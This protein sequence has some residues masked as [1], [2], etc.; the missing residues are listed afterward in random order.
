MKYDI[1]D[2]QEVRKP[3]RNLPPYFLGY[4]KEEAEK[5]FKDFSNLLNRISYSFSVYTG[6][7][8][9]D[10]FGEALNGLAV[11]KRDCSPGLKHSFKAYA[12]VI[13]IDFLNEYARKYRATVVT[14]SYVRKANKY[15][16]EL[17]HCLSSTGFE[18]QVHDTS[19]IP[20][21]CIEFFDKLLRASKRAS[22]TVEE[23]VKRAEYLPTNTQYTENE[24]E[25]SNEEEVSAAL[26]VEKIKEYMTDEELII[27]DGIMQGKTLGE[28]G[29][30]LNISGSAVH[31]RLTKF[32]KRIMEKLD[33]EII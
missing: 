27:A 29:E 13:I 26:L 5:T 22:I 12:T 23:L 2:N 25:D 21:E 15:I 11:A 30:D 28:I 10:L 4:T 6:L 9:S 19:N 33:S 14:P 24:V 1:I 8:Q 32:K 18:S 3:E 7:D 16:N 31:Q 20:E 17:K